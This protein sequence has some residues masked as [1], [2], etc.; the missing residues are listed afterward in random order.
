MAVE[1]LLEVENIHK[2]YEGAQG[3][4]PALRGVTFSV[5]RG[6]FLAVRGPSGCGKS[7]L[8]HIVGAMDRPSRGTVRL[9]GLAL[10]GLPPHQLA[11]V[12]RRQIGFVFQSFNLLPTLTVAENVVLP[13]LLDGQAARTARARVL[14]LLQQV[15]LLERAEH[16]PAQLSGGEMQR[17]AVARAVAAAPD[18]VLADE[19]TGNLDS[20]NGARIMQL[21]AELNQRFGMTVLLATHSD[22]AAAYARRALHLR[23]G[24]LERI[25][26]DEKL[27]ES[28]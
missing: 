5:S 6:D 2:I 28:V 1:P 14:E 21:L 17:V 20:Q 19:P 24:R 9:G 11:R 3:G 12:R 27:A 16:F 7:T 23:D 13:L 10:D 26:G 15:G 8:L 18:L 25:D 22:E 4:V